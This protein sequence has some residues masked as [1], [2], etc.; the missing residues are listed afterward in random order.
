MTTTSRI[1]AA[2]A[3]AALTATAARADV[4]LTVAAYPPLDD[5][6]RAAVPAFELSHPG[7]KIKLRTL[8]YGDFKKGMKEALENGGNLPDVL[9]LEIG[10]AQPFALTG[11]LEDLSAPPYNARALLPGF[12]DYTVP[13]VR[14]GSTIFA[15]PADVG[16]GTLFYRKDIL[17]QAGVSEADLT[18]SWDSFIE[19][20][21]RVRAKTGAALV[22]DVYDLYSIELRNGVKPGDSVYFDAA[23]KP[24]VDAPRFQ[25]AFALARKAQDAGIDARVGTW[26][27]EWADALRDGKLAAQPTGAWFG[28]HLK[29]WLA[30]KSAGLWR[31]APLP[32]GEYG[33][34]GGSFWSIPRASAHKAQAWE[35]VRFLCLDRGQ[36]LE[37]F[38]RFD[39]F[40]AL[41]AAQDAPAMDEPIA[42]LGG[43][44]ARQLWRASAAKIPALSAH[45]QD[46]DASAIVYRALLDVLRNGKE[47]PAALAD[48]RAKLAALAAA[49]APAPSDGRLSLF[50]DAP[51]ERTTS[52]ERIELVVASYPSFDMSVKVAIPRFE[53][54]HPNIK[55]KLVSKAFG[56]HHSAMIR[57]LD[58]GSGLPDVMAVEVGFV[59]RFGES[60]ALDDLGEVPYNGRPA[61][62]ALFPFSVAQG[63]WNGR[64]VGMPADVGPGTL[65]Y[66]KDLLDRAGVTEADLTRSWDSYLEAGKKVKAAT[67][68]SLLAHV[69]ALKDIYLRSHL[70]PGEGVYFDESGEPLLTTPRFAEA[71]ALAR[72]ARDAGLD[73]RVG[74]WSNE[75]ADGLKRGTIATE[76][77][78][79]WLA[80]HLANWLAPDGRGLWRAAP[81]PGGA[82]VTWG[83]SFYAIPGKAAHRKEA[84]EFVK[85]LCFDAE[86]QSDAF[87]N[88]DAWPALRAA[89]DIPLVDQPIP[90]LGG[91]RARQVWKQAAERVPVIPV[92]RLDPIAADQVNKALEDVLVRGKDIE[93]A[94][95]EAQQLLKQR[96]RR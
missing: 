51:A 63:Q 3:L 94:L 52:G 35:L 15:L 36:Q 49:P 22:G 20:G 42:Y 84:W 88:L 23:G 86:Q 66:R 96:L 16:P 26:S 34:W 6:L 70:S 68:A 44:K 55:V 27:N 71:F 69:G 29:T 45:P 67:G 62:A 24:A 17:D 57:A 37:A 30:P 14:S 32:E 50:S 60:R 10:F 4:E 25:R 33:A 19:A 75:W 83:G 41:K 91:Q 12:L 39:A 38:N 90:Y 54:L 58:S 11:Q 77:N 5:S 78:G 87:N 76:P 8:P 61:T 13:Q 53:R 18:R 81:L 73:A 21:K 89:Q 31:A 82:A 80:G 74:N 1:A 7:V 65:F 48:A 79:A 95:A 28:G 93:E 43:Q 92:N 72:R 85:F 47:I 46:S 56:D 59:G 9:A 64:L 2:L 40:P